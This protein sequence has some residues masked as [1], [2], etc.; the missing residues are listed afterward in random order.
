MRSKRWSPT[1][2][3]KMSDTAPAANQGAAEPEAEAVTP[4]GTARLSYASSFTNPFKANTV[5]AM[6]WATGKVTLLRLLQRFQRMGPASGQEFWDQVAEV[7]GIAVQT[8]PEQL[9]RIP[10][11]GPVVIVANHPRGPVDGMVLAKLIGQVRHDYK[12]LARSLLPVAGA[13]GQFTIPV[14]FPHEPGAAARSL[15]MRRTARAHLANDGVI[16]LFPAGA[17]AASQTLRGPAVEAAWA[18]FTAKLIA[19]SGATVVPVCFAGQNSRA[20]QV[21]NRVSATLRQG[22]LLHEVVH[23]LNKPQ[24]PVIGHPICPNEVRARAGNPRSCAAW[25]RSQTLALQN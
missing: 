24:A 8:P 22:L 1:V 21:A 18:P 19:H 12:I 14:P 9:Q 15:E 16:A 2:S 13:I 10:S 4:Y 11:Q 5:R 25:L 20:Y 3:V 23:A 6:E 17:V 7:M